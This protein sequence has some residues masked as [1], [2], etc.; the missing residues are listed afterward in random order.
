MLDALYRADFQL[1]ERIVDTQEDQLEAPFRVQGIDG[2]VHQL[3]KPRITFK[4]L[5]ETKPG[6][7]QWYHLKDWRAS[8]PTVKWNALF[9]GVFHIQANLRRFPFDEQLLTIELQAG[10][11]LQPTAQGD[12][13]DPWQ[14][15]GVCL[16]KNAAQPSV[17]SLGTTSSAVDYQ[18]RLFK[19]LLFDRDESDPNDSSAGK[20]YSKLL[21]SM[22]V[23]RKAGF[24][25]FN[26]MIPN[27]M[28]TGSVLASY[29]EP[30]SDLGT[31]LQI[32][33][34]VL[35]ALTSELPTPALTPLSP[36]C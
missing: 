30:A 2:T 8:K 23:Q 5:I 15:Y 3:F 28:I 4:N 20:V 33:V 26:I 19:E 24:F 9:T 6:L 32:T 14:Q 11:E 34:T 31:R 25:L 35:L 1:S 29:G 13:K 18:Y 22:H 10:W 7:K 12:K 16:R 21:I 27:F 17:I 36:P